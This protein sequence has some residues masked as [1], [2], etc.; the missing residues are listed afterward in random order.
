MTKAQIKQAHDLLDSL[1]KEVDAHILEDGNDLAFAM[2]VA[3]HEGAKQMFRLL[4]N[5]SI[6][7]ETV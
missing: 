4:L 2:S 6:E 3:R 1:A 7:A 5:L